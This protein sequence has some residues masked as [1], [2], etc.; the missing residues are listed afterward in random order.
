MQDQYQE[1][2]Q[3]AATALQRGEDANWELARLTYENTWSGHGPV[4][5]GYVSMETWCGDIR[6]RSSRRFS[7]ETGKLYKRIWDKYRQE[8]TDTLSW[9]DAYYTTTSDTPEK[10]LD[11]QRIGAIERATPEAKVD[12]FKR[13]ASDPVVMAA[14]EVRETI[15]EAVAKSPA[16]TSQTISRA[17]EVRPTPPAPRTESAGFEWEAALGIGSEILTDAKRKAE[18][19]SRLVTLIRG[20]RESLSEDARAAVRDNIEDI[21]QAAETYRR[22]AGEIELALGGQDSDSWLR[23]VLSE[24]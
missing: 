1:A 20:R 21:R 14:P 7:V 8:P 16:L 13:L 15:V 4:P 10:R 23:S 12:A 11:R 5:A 19:V 6:Q 22:F 2:V 24:A 9:T 17:Q 3:L 18:R